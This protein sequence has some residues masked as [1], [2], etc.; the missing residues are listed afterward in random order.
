[1][2]SWSLGLQASVISEN[3]IQAE[4]T[5]DAKTEFNYRW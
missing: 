4:K 1:M 5:A 3:I 2:Y